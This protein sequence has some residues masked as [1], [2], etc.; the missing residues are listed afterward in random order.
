MLQNIYI[1]TGSGISNIGKGWLTASIGSLLDSALPIKIDPML[2]KE[3]PSEIGIKLEEKIV[4]EDFAIYKEL[5]LPVYPE[6]NIMGGDLLHEFL[7]QP[8]KKLSSNITKKK[9]FAD[10]SD[11]LADRIIKIADSKN[12]KNLVIELGG[13]S[14]DIEHN[15]IYGAMRALGLKINVIPEIVLLSYLEYDELDK[16][17]FSLKTQNIRKAVK[18][19]MGSYYSLPLKVCFV[20]RRYVPEKITD[21]QI[22][23]ELV[24]IAYETQISL[25][26]IVYLPNFNDVHDLRKIID[27]TKLFKVKNDSYLV[28]ACLLGIPCR[29]DGTTEELDYKAVDLLKNK[30][31]FTMCPEFLV[32]LGI[33]RGPFEIVGG[34]GYDV[35][36]GN[37]KVMSIDGKDHT[38]KFIE[39][40]QKALEIVK[41]K[42][43]TTAVL[44]SKS[45]T[46]GCS[47]IFDGS[48]TKKLKEGYGVFGAL[49]E[50]N[51]IKCIP[52][53]KL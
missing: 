51:G 26:K 13:T 43:I 7:Q 53:T 11:L 21:Q 1:V 39:A 14:K 25:K 6:C 32:G 30:G 49:L 12:I 28:S 17:I 10:L 23:G 45:P 2:N 4:S 8:E 24:N 52:N 42:S 47:K 46:C 50:R 37:A 29:Y 20:R 15:Y 40:A 3:F 41:E 44:Y 38:Q 16:G 27:Q 9:T 33:P 22:K 35:L 19:T 31:V 48:F 34:D 36:D 18:E 5:G